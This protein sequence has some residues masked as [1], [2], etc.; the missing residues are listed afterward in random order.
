M[1]DM[2]LQE[3]KAL[4]KLSRI[5]S[6][7]ADPCVINTTFIAPNGTRYFMHQSLLEYPEDGWSIRVIEPVEVSA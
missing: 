2:T 3:A 7:Y 1:D 6:Q 4:M 5:V